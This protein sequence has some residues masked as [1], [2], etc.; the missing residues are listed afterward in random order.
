MRRSRAVPLAERAAEFARVFDAR[1]LE[2][3]RVALP[4]ARPGMGDTVT[5]KGLVVKRGLWRKWQALRW[6]VQDEQDQ[7][8][9]HVAPTCERSEW[10]HDDEGE[11][12]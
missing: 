12:K 8:L 10:P 2:S 11:P 9:F 7:G 3:V 6:V 5:I 4:R 1:G